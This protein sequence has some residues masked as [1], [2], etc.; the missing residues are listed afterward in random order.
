MLSGA[1]AHPPGETLT[2]ADFMP[3]LSGQWSYGLSA[4]VLMAHFLNGW[5]QSTWAASA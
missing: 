2:H 1:E 5:S 4:L 3:N